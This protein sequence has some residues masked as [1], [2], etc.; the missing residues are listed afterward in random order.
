MR[1][2]QGLGLMQNRTVFKYILAHDEVG[3]DG[4]DG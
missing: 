3:S 4:W 2:A 1:A